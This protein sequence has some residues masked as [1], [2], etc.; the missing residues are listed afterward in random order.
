MKK[1]FFLFAVLALTA[2]SK[3]LRDV[4][5]PS[6]PGKPPE[7][8]EDNKPQIAEK[9]AAAQKKASKISPMNV[10]VAGKVRD[11]VFFLGGGLQYC[12]SQNNC[13]PYDYALLKEKNPVFVNPGDPTHDVS[14]GVF[15]NNTPATRAVE[16]CLV[17]Q[18]RAIAALPVSK[19][20]PPV[21]FV[22]VLAKAFDQAYS[23]GKAP[24]SILRKVAFVAED[25]FGSRGEL[26][27]TNSLRIDI[28][29]HVQVAPT[30]MCKA[31]PMEQ[32]LRAAGGN[33]SQGLGE[34]SI[35]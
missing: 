8:I 10:I 35:D 16:D 9:L 22:R 11:D 19:D 6:D 7:K 13:I 1:I 34:S 21:I 26:R 31:I 30:V 18:A 33:L 3:G 28:D 17:V 14:Y 2:C 23:E 32:I 12:R 29:M 4:S 24:N 5:M 15:T 27:A 20:T 25:K